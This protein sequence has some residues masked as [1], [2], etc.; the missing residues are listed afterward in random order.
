MGFYLPTCVFSTICAYISRDIYLTVRTF[1][2][3][4]FIFSHNADYS[5]VY[6]YLNNLQQYVGMWVNLSLAVIGWC[7][8][9]VHFK[10]STAL[11]PVK[12]TMKILNKHL[13]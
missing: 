2:S 13:K 5:S 11:I 6:I 12:S 4:S 3:F 9:S 8:I 1:S 10:T 7:G